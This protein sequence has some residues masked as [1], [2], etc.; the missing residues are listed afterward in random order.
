MRKIK[1]ILILAGGDSSRFWPL[2]N[3]VIFPFLG[4]PLIIYQIKKLSYFGEKIFVVVHQTNAPVIKRLID[5]FQLT[6]NVEVII[7]QSDL[8]GQAG[9]IDTV[10]NF[11]HGEILIVNANDKL[12]F[13]FL[14]NI[15]KLSYE[16]NKIIL[17]GKKYH[18]YFHGGYF[19]F[20]SNNQ[21]NSVVEKPKK[22]E[23]PS[24]IVKLV[25]DYFSDFK[26]LTK[27]I[28]EVKTK[29][30][31]IYEQAIN[32]ILKTSIKK[33]YL[34]YDG[35]WQS[36]KYSWNVLPMMKKYLMEIKK[37]DF[38]RT[39]RISKKATIL[40][41]VIIEDNAV[42][43]DYVKVVG[44]TY[45]GKNSIIGDY[46]LI[47]ESQIGDDCLIGSYSE[48]ARSYIGNKVFLHRNYV[49]D[50]VLSDEVM[51]GAQAVTANLRFDGETVSSFYDEE[52]VDTYL[53]KLGAII[54]R[55][56][57][58]GVNSTILPGVKIGE[59]TWIGPGETV[60]YDIEDCSY[61]FNGEE[62]E[63]LKV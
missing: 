16:E 22:E 9:A 17:T 42:I 60:F 41:P 53:S 21:I 18:E 35:D 54:G 27:A 49:G 63:N 3:K 12:D 15:T 32:L 33:S 48:V 28:T 10:K 58:I 51:M 39:A 47:R 40:G 20:D 29:N 4:V 37:S 44:P 2:K 19:K 23:V 1:N 50:S 46:S 7:Q 14:E 26:I 6:N 61:L 59:K 43:G 36:L 56:S 8:V 11:I 62:K 38:S 52:K 34:I 13:S 45:V 5:N 24:N 31:D 25:V 57:K 55:Q 30:D